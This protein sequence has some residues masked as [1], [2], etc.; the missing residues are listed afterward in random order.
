MF[1]PMQ[2]VERNRLTQEIL[3]D[4]ERFSLCT[5][6]AASYIDPAVG[7]HWEIVR[8]RLESGCAFRLLILSPFREEKRLRDRRNESGDVVDSKLR[9]EQIAR[10]AAEYE[11]FSVKVSYSNIYA[12]VFFSERA[13][14]YDPYH[15]GKLTTRIENRFICLAFDKTDDTADP[16]GAY[17]RSLTS[18]FEF[19]WGEAQPLDQFVRANETAVR[20]YVGTR[21]KNEIDRVLGS[22]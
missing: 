15:L 18:H 16:D 9:L 12:A 6:T 3:R 14:T 10:I 2:Q 5:L 1:D 20:Q 7:R 17:F 22:D 4:G 11:N 8:S 13:M 19:L 21:A